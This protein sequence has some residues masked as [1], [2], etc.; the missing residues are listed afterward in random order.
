MRSKGEEKR[1]NESAQDTQDDEKIQGEK[2]ENRV[3]SPSRS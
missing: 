3:Q 2:D 1:A